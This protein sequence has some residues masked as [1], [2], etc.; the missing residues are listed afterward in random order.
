MNLSFNSMK[1]INCRGRWRIF[2]FERIL[3]R[4][5]ALDHL[6]AGAAVIPLLQSVQGVLLIVR[7]VHDLDPMILVVKR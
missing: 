2:E 4:D 3:N 1:T 7:V 5:P 6:E